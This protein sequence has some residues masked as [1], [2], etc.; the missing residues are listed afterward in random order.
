MTEIQNPKPICNPGKQNLSLVIWIKADTI[1][2]YCSQSFWSL[3][4]GI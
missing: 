3:N 2:E 4:F 1:S